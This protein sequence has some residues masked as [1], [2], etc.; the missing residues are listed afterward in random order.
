MLLALL[1]VAFATGW[2]AF[3]FATAPSR[4]SLVAHAVAGC[5]LV[6]LIPSKSALSRSGVARRRSGW[7]LSLLLGLL[8]TVSLAAGFMHSLGM[9]WLPAGLTALDF[10]VGAALVLVP[11][12][13]WHFVARPV[14]LRR[15]DLS[16]RRLLRGAGL[17]GAAAALYGS[18]ELLD[19]VA[20]W[21]G[22]SRRFSGSYEVG[23]GDPQGLP[24]TQW[25]FDQVPATDAPSWTLRVAGRE[26]S[27]TDLAGFGDSVTAT[28][29]CTGGFFSEHE[30]Q[31]CRLSR[32]L[33]SGAVGASIR[34]Q[35][36]TGYE[37]SFPVEEA[38]R[39]LLATRIDG[40]PLPVGNGFP[41]RLVAPGRRGFWWVKWVETIELDAAPY[42]WQLPFPLH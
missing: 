36:H 4:W 2:L 39:L 20:G 31:G 21:P 34:V 35:S 6:L 25:L 29:D 18:S 41:V 17:I 23:S 13:V 11:I 5:A 14:R 42:W 19:R 28:L 40:Q 15:T 27:H 30:W 22:V 1:T 3:A 9:P 10:H 8:V 37:R 33:P 7:W 26:F 24:A 38:G 16:R 12:L 32:L